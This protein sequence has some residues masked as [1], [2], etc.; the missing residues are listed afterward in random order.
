MNVSR[1]KTQEAGK[2]KRGVRDYVPRSRLAQECSD[3]RSLSLA[4]SFDEDRCANFYCGILA[5]FDEGP[6]GFT[7]K[8]EAVEAFGRLRLRTRETE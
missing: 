4:R 6:Q 1:S 7:M 5:D 3:S 2:R 8:P